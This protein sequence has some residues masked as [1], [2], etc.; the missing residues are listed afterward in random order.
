MDGESEI[1]SHEVLRKEPPTGDEVHELAEE[2]G[3]VEIGV[4]E[5]EESY[6]LLGESVHRI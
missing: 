5:P 1:E 3:V 2:H 4:N 6:E